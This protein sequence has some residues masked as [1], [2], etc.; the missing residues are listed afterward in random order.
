MRYRGIKATALIKETD[1]KYPA[2]AEPIQR[3]ERVTSRR[4]E[5]V[6]GAA[7]LCAL[8][9]SGC[10]SMQD[11]IMKTRD[12]GLLARDY[13]P[14]PIIRHT[15]L[16][17]NAILKIND[18]V[19]APSPENAWNQKSRFNALISIF[20]IASALSPSIDMYNVHLD[21]SIPFPPQAY[22]LGQ[23]EAEEF[24]V[25]AVE[26]SGLFK[27]VILN[28][29]IY[30][31]E[32]RGSI[33]FIRRERMH[34]SGLGFVIIMAPLWNWWVPFNTVHMECQ[35]NLEVLRRGQT[36]AILS[37]SYRE[38]EVRT[39]VVLGGK[40]A[41]AFMSTYAPYFSKIVRRFVDD[42]AAAL[43]T[44]RTPIDKTKDAQ[45]AKRQ[46]K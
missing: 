27:S 30:D 41:E 1:M 6:A 10:A 5:W 13:I 22:R 38:Y 43:A 45:G 19:S 36:N 37:R 18:L 39:F 28:G 24:L 40:E 15:T 17:G 12:R 31:Y 33:D 2:N 29:E 25:E 42:L 9:L 4:R 14:P 16:D 11:C 3:D 23:W 8:L 46:T 32:V 20:P 21:M 26:R 44:H 7:M 35:A 34:C